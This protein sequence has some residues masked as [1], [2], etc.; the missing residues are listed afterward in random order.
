MQ[1]PTE[2][3]EELERRADEARNGLRAISALLVNAL[4]VAL[5]EMVERETITSDTRDTIWQR[6]GVE[7]ST[8]AAASEPVSRAAAMAAMPHRPKPKPPITE[9]APDR[10][11]K[12]VLGLR[13][14]KS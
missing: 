11:P 8:A 12:D 14:R 7:I 1:T 10:V 4:G 9:T 3:I 13:P 2:R 6:I 5:D